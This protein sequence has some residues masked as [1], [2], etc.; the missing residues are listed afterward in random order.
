MNTIKPAKGSVR[1]KKRV[2]RG[3]ASGHGTYSTRGLKGQ[4][5]RS[6]VSYF[7]LKRLG[8]KPMLLNIPKKRGFNSGKPKNQVIDINKI[9]S[10]YKEGEEVNPKTLIKSGLIKSALIPI[11][12]LGNTHLKVK[13]L[14]FKDVKFSQTAKELA[15][16][17]G[18][19]IL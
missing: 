6:G 5:S 13:G 15:E 12:I 11:K 9:N 7:K 2:G 19:K 18:A 8:M 3:N 17:S 16:K 14:K 10:Y 1:K 4:R